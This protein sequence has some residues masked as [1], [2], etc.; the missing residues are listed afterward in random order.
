MTVAVL[1]VIVAM[2]VIKRRAGVSKEE[3]TNTELG[4]L[5]SN[6]S[7]TTDGMVDANPLFKSV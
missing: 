5:T 2:A 4:N 3:S 7:F 6:P 1:V